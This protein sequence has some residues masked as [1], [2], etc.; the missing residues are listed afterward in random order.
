MTNLRFDF[1]GRRV[2]VSGAAQGIGR[3]I[4]D[5]FHAA[6]AEVVAVDRDAEGLAAVP[7]ETR[8]C[9]LSKAAAADALFA[10][11]GA[12]DI[13][14]NAAGGVVGQTG[15]PLETVSDDDYRAVCAANLDTA[16]FGVRACVSEMK[17]RESGRIVLIASGAGLRASL[18]GIQAYAA[19]KHAV[20]GLTRQLALELGTFGITVNAVAPGFVL[21]NPST[22]RQWEALGS[23]GQRQLVASTHRRRLGTAADIAASVLFLCSSEADWITGQVVSVDGG[24]A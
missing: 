2:V 3:A 4:V 6:G 10:E 12:V 7:V 13:F 8:S 11:T 24:R 14:V 17:A 23:D 16:F 15:K 9:D 22:Q 1:S 20:V 5:S 18:T 19:S 21:S